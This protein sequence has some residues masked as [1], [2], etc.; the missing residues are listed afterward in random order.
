M[1]PP[2]LTSEVE[3]ERAYDDA[4]MMWHRGV[5]PDK[6]LTVECEECSDI[7]GCEEQDR[8]VWERLPGLAAS[9]TV[10]T[11]WPSRRNSSTTGNGKFSSARKRATAAQAASWSRICAEICSRCERTYAHA[12]ARSSARSAGYVRSKSASLDP[13]RL[14]CSNSQTGMRVRTMIG[15]P[16]QTSSITSMPGDA[17]PKS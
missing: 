6:V 17:S 3:V 7:G 15:S 8:L 13:S 9:A 2:G 12:F 14:A 5:Q 11:S 10:T 1:D 16:P 4:C